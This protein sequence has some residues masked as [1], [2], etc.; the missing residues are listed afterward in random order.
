MRITDSSVRRAAMDQIAKGRR[1]LT[2]KRMR[3]LRC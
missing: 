3:R 1:A 2:A